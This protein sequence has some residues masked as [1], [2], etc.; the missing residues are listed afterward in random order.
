MTAAVP[1]PARRVLVAEDNPIN[2]E[3][4]FEQLQL[5]GERADIA[6]DGQQALQAWREHHH[7]LVL[8]DLQMPSMDG[9]QLAR[10]I[11]A[12]EARLGLPRTAIVALSALAEAVTAGNRDLVAMDDHLSKPIQLPTLQAALVRWLPAADG[13][14]GPSLAQPASPGCAAEPDAEPAVGTPV[15]APAVLDVQVLRQYVGDD[16]A[17]VRQFLR[18]FHERLDATRADM[19]AAWQAGDAPL[20]GRLAH[21]LKSAARTVGA[22]QLADSCHALETEATAGEPPPVAACWAEVQQ[23]LARANEAL[24]RALHGD[25]GPNTGGQAEGS[26]P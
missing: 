14:A 7:R 20:L 24:N 10:A 19:T 8:T 16:D 22:L 26:K 11:R 2:Q 12:D 1:R 18:G 15:A 23:A 3:V 25:G 5:L 13:D 21:R 6:S 9:Y 17:V 4:L